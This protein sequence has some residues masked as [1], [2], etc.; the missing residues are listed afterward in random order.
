VTPRA[1]A[2]AAALLGGAW[3]LLVAGPHTVDPREI[4]WL[5]RGD[6]G[7]HLLGFLFSLEAPWSFPLGEVPELAWPVGTSVAFTDANPWLAT[8]AKLLAPVL[9]RE[10]QLIGPWLCFCFA[11]QGWAGARLVAAVTPRAWHQLLGGVLFAL[12]PPLLHRVGHD[13]LCAHFLLLVMLRLHLAPGRRPVLASAL[14]VGLAAGLHPYFVPML[15]VL[16]FALLVRLWRD[17]ALG[18]RGAWSG[19]A[20]LV[21]VGVAG[22]ALFGYFQPTSPV[23]NAFGYFQA[24]LLALVNPIDR[25]RFLPGFRVVDGQREG[26][27]Y[28][29]LGVLLA[30][31]AALASARRG[32][33]AIP[34]RR[35]GA[36][37]LAT[38]GLTLFSFSFT[39]RVAGRA[40]LDPGGIL[41]REPA[42]IAVGLTTVLVSAVL[43]VLVAR[44][45]G[46]LRRVFLLG[47]LALA[48]VA[49]LTLLF[50]P[51]EDIH[52]LTGPLNQLR[53]SGRFIWT[54]HYLVVV[55]AVA[56]VA[57]G[58]PPRVA[59]AVLAAAVALQIAETE[60]PARAAGMARRPAPA[61]SVWRSVAGEW[62][63]LAWVPQRLIDGAGMGCPPGPDA[64]WL[65]LALEAH[66]AG[67]TVN[68]AYVARLDHGPARAACAALEEALRAGRLDRDTLYVPTEEWARVLRGAGARC[69]RLDGHLL[70]VTP[71]RVGPLPEALAPWP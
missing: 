15:L 60:I 30:G 69:G 17:G 48:A 26:F 10:L 19:A 36:L 57:R 39:W 34:W 62:R 20:S 18:A 4:G 35:H 13:T 54:L 2:A 24:D 47:G 5:L 12:A 44:R 66:R 46:A 53:A 25:S 43:V 42:A 33:V 45:A 14:L 71:D 16:A 55:A 52:V 31:A 65:P 50:V 9:P 41:R 23:R 59:T 38:A 61:S 64:S 40:V 49:G 3:F 51:R 28:L 37:L 63:H 56:G 27:A 21:A 58:L 11:A 68:S 32:R 1:A 29:G 70:C 67:L 8:L 7:Q 22:L 6:W